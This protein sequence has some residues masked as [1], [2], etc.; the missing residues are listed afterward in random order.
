MLAVSGIEQARVRM[1]FSNITFK[2]CWKQNECL[3]M[4]SQLYVNALVFQGKCWDN[5][6]QENSFN[7]ENSPRIRGHWKIYYIIMKYWEN[8]RLVGKCTN[9]KEN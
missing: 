3:Q 2:S 1:I 7:K 5:H 8:E 6:S 9:M 4:Y